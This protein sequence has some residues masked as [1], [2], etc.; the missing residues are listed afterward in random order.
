M[1]SQPSGFFLDRDPDQWGDFEAFILH[2]QGN[3][4]RLSHNADKYLK[5]YKESLNIIKD[6]DIFTIDGKAT[7]ER[8]LISDLPLEMRRA[9]ERVKEDLAQSQDAIAPQKRKAEREVTI[10]EPWLSLVM[11]LTG[12]VKGEPQGV[13]IRTDETMSHHHQILYDFVFDR[14]TKRD[15]LTKQS[16]FD[17]S[18]ALSGIIN[19]R[20]KDASKY[21]G[22]NTLDVIKSKCFSN[23][24]CRPDGIPG[25][26]TTLDE[27][28]LDQFIHMRHVDYK[29]L[30][31]QV[32]LLKAKDI[33]TNKSDPIREATQLVI[34]IVIELP[35]GEI[36]SR[37]TKHQ[38]TNLGLGLN[39][40]MSKGSGGKRLDLQCR[41]VDKLELNNS[42][43]KR[44]STSD[45]QVDQQLQKNVL[46]NHSMVLYLKE[47]IGLPLDQHEVHAL[48]VHGKSFDTYIH[49]QLSAPIIDVNAT[50]PLA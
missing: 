43:F 4:P 41:G 50:A 30:S 10:K 24:F 34:D 26:K 42:E 14:L 40:E 16:E 15:S 49:T 44:S 48:N 20:M 33:E 7:A 36:P 29:G 23:N 5:L 45:T 46:I 32:T 8:L 11:H 39:I 17:V 47:E 19:A 27:L 35:S 9:W 3:T 28:N 13:L 22:Q 25:L 18:V 38:S 31:Q 21:F 6:D 12:R 37:A 2:R 1:S